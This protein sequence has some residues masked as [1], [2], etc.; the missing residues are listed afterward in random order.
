MLLETDGV[1]D[2]YNMTINDVTQNIDVS[3]SEVPT[4]GA[5]ILTKEA[6]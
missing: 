2:Y 5:I 3:D 1:D 6:D 4:V